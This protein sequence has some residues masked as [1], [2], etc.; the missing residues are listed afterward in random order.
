MDVEISHLVEAA[1]IDILLEK[2]YRVVAAGAVDKKSAP[3]AFGLVNNST[4]GKEHLCVSLFAKLKKSSKS[5]VCTK[6]VANLDYDLTLSLADLKTVLAL[7]EA[8]ALLN[9]DISV[10][11]ECEIDI[12]DLL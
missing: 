1:H 5:I 7:G 3:V 12:V 8:L 11:C 2:I 10:I 9:N 4:A 6:V